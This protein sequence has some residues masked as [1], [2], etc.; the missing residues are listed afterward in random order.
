VRADSGFLRSLAAFEDDDDRPTNAPRVV[1][2]NRLAQ[3]GVGRRLARLFASIQVDVH[4]S[5]TPR[6]FVFRRASGAAAGPVRS[7]VRPA[8]RGDER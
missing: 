8:R 5:K 6:L 1:S 2:V 3:R 4:R 7:V